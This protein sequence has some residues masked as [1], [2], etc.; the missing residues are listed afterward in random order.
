MVKNGYEKIS[1]DG[2]TKNV[3]F[4][5]VLFLQWM[6]IV[7]KKGNERALEQ[8][9]FLPLLK[10]N[11]TSF[12]FE[13]LQSKW[14]DEQKTSKQSGKNPKLWKSVLKM[15]SVKEFMIFASIY[16]FYTLSRIL[17]PLLL[18]YL[19]AS[20]TSSEPQQNYLLYGCA[21]AMGINALI[22]CLSM[23]YSEYRFELWGIRISSA[24]KG[25]VYLKVSTISCRQPCLAT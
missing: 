15:I 17:L 16:M 3:G 8:S 10:E 5:S 11:S 22:G 25:L 19:I 6:N 14:K 20:M 2:D 9:D 4:F 23:H 24:I 21:L 12:V 18:G 1:N 7:F 13:H